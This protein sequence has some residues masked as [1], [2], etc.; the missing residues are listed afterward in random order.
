MLWNE[1]EKTDATT[2]QLASGRGWMSVGSSEA[3]EAHLGSL[4]QSHCDKPESMRNRLSQD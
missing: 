4:G 1:R 3:Q 2:M